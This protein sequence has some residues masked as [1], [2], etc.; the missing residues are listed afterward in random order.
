MGRLLS[1][2]GTGFTMFYAPIFFV[3]QVGLS[4]TAVGIGLGSGSISGVVGRFLGGSFADSKF[5]GRRRTLLLSAAVSAVASVMLALTYN[6]PTFIVGNL[7]MGLGIGLYWP[8]TE[9]A[10]A[11]LTTIEQLNE[12]FAITRL[13]DSLGLGLGVVL[14]GALIGT[15]GNYRA[16]FVIDAVSFVVFLGI[17]YAAIPETRKFDEHLPKQGSRGWAVALSDRH[18]MVYVLVNILFTTYLAQVNSTMPLYF[19]N[20]VSSKTSIGGFSPKVISAL[21]TWHVVCAALCQLPVARALN[22][23]SRP[24]ALTVSMLLWCAGFV[25]IWVTGVASVGQIIWAIL[26]LGVLAIA[27][28]AYTP[29]AS[30][31]V[32]DLA[33]ESLRGVYLSINSQCWAI[34]YFI[35]PILGGW[36]LDQSHGVSEAMPKGLITHGFWLAAAAS[37]S[38]GIL[39]LQYLNGILTT[40]GSRSHI[41]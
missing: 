11:D 39:I 31:L 34:G 18:L 26:G 30:A 20:F 23:F 16:L 3:N 41:P 14:G 2:I 19:T 29:S 38:I 28:V 40:R 8:A 35:G 24:R 32:V 5:W 37:T 27:T 7:L 13:A 22:R 17:V 9:A 1:Q 36:V 4:A 6:F 10:V 25:L 21:F 15:T 33:P 12:A